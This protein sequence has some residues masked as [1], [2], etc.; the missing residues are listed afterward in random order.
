MANGL[1]KPITILQI[2][3]KTR[4]FPLIGFFGSLQLVQN[5]RFFALKKTLIQITRSSRKCFHTIMA[6]SFYV[7]IYFRSHYHSR[8]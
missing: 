4:R 5:K 3:P 1:P 6:Q 7:F 2:Y 8:L